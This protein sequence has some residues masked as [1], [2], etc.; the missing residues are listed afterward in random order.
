M[1][2]SEQ[3]GFPGSREG[4]PALPEPRDE[5]KAMRTFAFA[6]LAASTF[7][8]ATAAHAFINPFPFLQRTEWIAVA[9]SPNGSVFRRSHEDEQ[10]ARSAA[11]FA[12]EQKT[13]RTC[14]VIAVPTTWDV[15]VMT[16]SRPGQP[17]LPIVGGSGQ[18]AAI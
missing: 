6:A 18:N 3:G 16:C 2:I 5:D 1:L 14:A 13:G 10:V 12:C 8:T 4:H 7:L 17:P 9:A 15:V 11:K